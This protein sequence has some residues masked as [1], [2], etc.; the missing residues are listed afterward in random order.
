MKTDN[1]TNIQII[2][3]KYHYDANLFTKGDI[4]LN[5]HSALDEIEG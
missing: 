4:L 5:I 1:I 2:N 3:K